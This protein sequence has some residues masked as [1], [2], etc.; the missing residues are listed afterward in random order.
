MLLDFVSVV[1]LCCSYMRSFSGI[2]Q[3]V[4]NFSQSQAC[5]HMQNH[6]FQSC[7]LFLSKLKY[8]SRV[9]KRSANLPF[10]T[11]E[12]LG[13]PMPSV[14]KTPSSKVVFVLMIYFG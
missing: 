8:M 14:M 9:V 1:Y 4:R 2:L 12:S 13:P 10:R 7:K 11:T 5:F 6:M 3:Q